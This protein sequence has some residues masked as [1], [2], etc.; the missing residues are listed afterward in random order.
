[1]VERFPNKAVSLAAS[2]RLEQ[3]L[4]AGNDFRRATDV[5][6][7]DQLAPWTKNPLYLSDRRCIVGDRAQRE[8][9]YDRVKAPVGELQLLRISQA[10]LGGGIDSARRP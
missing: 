2:K 4:D 1:M 5:F 7:C 6:D 9:A 10:E 3:A 8:G